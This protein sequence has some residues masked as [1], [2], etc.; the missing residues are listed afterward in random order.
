MRCLKLSV[1]SKGKAQYILPE[2][3]Q[4]GGIISQVKTFGLR[5][6]FVSTVGRDEETVKKYIKKQEDTD[7]K[8]DQ[9]KLF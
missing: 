4:D 2:R 1:M 7:R 9:L 5:G 8:I 3:M 6:Y